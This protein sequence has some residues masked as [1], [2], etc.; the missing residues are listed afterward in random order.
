MKKDIPEVNFRVR[1]GPSVFLLLWLA[2]SAGLA[3]VEAYYENKTKY[4][5]NKRKQRIDEE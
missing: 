2:G 4:E 3:F 1:F 5:Y